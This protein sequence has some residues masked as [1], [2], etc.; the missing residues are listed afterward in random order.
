MIERVEDLEEA[1]E[2]PVLVEFP[3]IVKYCAD[4]F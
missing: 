2:T 1:T 3:N 4:M